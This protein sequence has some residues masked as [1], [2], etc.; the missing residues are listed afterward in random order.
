[1]MDEQWSFGSLQ[2]NNGYLDYSLDIGY[3]IKSHQ[4]F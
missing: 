4:L 3:A 2:V 1:M